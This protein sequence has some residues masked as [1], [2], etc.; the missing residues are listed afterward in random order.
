MSESPMLREDRDSV[1][2]LTL[3]RTR[4]L[5]A[6]S[7]DLLD[8]LDRHLDSIENDPAVRAMVIT[9]AGRA[10]CAGSDLSHRGEMSVR[11]TRMHRL[12]QRFCGYPKPTV[13]ALNGLAFGGGLELALACDFRIARSVPTSRPSVSRCV[14]HQ[15]ALDRGIG[16]ARP[17]DRQPEKQTSAEGFARRGVNLAGEEEAQ[18]LAFAGPILAQE[19]EIGCQPPHDQFETALRKR[20]V[21][22]IVLLAD[23][24]GQRVVQV[25]RQHQFGDPGKARECLLRH[26][27]HQRANRSTHE[28]SS[29]EARAGDAAADLAMPSNIA[30]RQRYSGPYSFSA[31]AKSGLCRESSASRSCA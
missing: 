4:V 12:V 27:P 5:N 14:L 25:R 28:E 29:T 15:A 11:V 30:V 16:L 21:A 20:D 2:V 23:G 8:A 17:R 9:G 6:I 13:A 1:A 19:G 24:R 10:F 26:L 18:H 7:D 22:F 3:N 31:M